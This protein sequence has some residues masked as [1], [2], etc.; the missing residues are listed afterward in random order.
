MLSKADLAVSR[1][2]DRS[3]RYVEEEQDDREDFLHVVIVVVT[4][5]RSDG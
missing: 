1:S 5:R 2:I 4:A 3:V